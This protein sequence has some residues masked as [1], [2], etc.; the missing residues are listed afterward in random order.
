MEKRVLVLNLDHSPVAVVPVQK[1]I[2]L[3]LLE[4]ANILSTYE[5][6]Q[7]R[8]V[9]RSFDYPAVIRLTQYKNI[10]FRG[11]LLNRSNLFKRDNGECQYC[12]SKRHLTIDHIIPKSKGGK[13]NWTN[14]VTACNRCNVNKGDKTPEQAGLVLRSQPFKPSLSYFLAEYAERQAEE[15]L[16]FLGSRIMNP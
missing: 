8:T 15:W 11:V 10:P 12:G 9:D 1:A 7:I 2:V 13:T 6:L 14:L 3:C 16:P 5:L 4:K